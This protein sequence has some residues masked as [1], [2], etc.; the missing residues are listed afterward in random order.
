LFGA[1]V[2]VRVISARELPEERRDSIRSKIADLGGHEDEVEFVVDQ[3]LVAGARVEFSSIAVDASLQ[4][5]LQA[6]RQQ[7]EKLTS[8]DRIEQAE[9]EESGDESPDDEEREGGD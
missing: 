6:A 7:F 8:E 9:A 1:D 4:D 5:A 3:D 2:P